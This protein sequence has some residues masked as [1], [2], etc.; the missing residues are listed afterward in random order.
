MIWNASAL[1]DDATYYIG[2]L[3][4]L[5]R[6]LLASHCRTHRQGRRLGATDGRRGPR[7]YRITQ[8]PLSRTTDR[9]ANCDGFS[10]GGAAALSR[11]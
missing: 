1:L 4:R 9:R 6:S 10:C 3:Y 7:C 8:R 2:G 11:P 5:V